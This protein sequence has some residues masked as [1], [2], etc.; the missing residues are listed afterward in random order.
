MKKIISSILTML[1]YI[2]GTAQQNNNVQ[3][4]VV[5]DTV[6]KTDSNSVKLEKITST[7]EDILAKL[8]KNDNDEKQ[9]IGVIKI[10]CDKPINLYKAKNQQKTA[11][12]EKVKVEKVTMQVKDGY[13]IDLNVY[14]DKGSFTNTESPITISTRRFSDSDYLFG[15]RDKSSSILLKEFLMFE[16]YNTY[17]PED[18]FIVL[19]CKKNSDSLF[20]N[21]GVN[22][23]L[24]MRLYTDALSL[25]GKESNGIAQ[26]D[27]RIKHILHRINVKNKGGF[28]GHYF[29]INVNAAKFDSK[30]NFVDS[31]KF[32]R[33]SFVQKSWINAEV[34]YNIL[35]AWIEK[36]S[37]S[38]FYFD[39]GAGINA[40]N[41][42]LKTDTITITG[43]NVL[44]RLG[45]T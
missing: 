20:R 24:D 25:F 40:G 5:K 21:V 1:I 43:Q 2:N 28:L 22:T 41:L 4:A 6:P 16:P 18:G 31:A 34:A 39:I 45:S 14:T 23:V 8:K 26:T 19:D 29:K 35:S 33:T 10:D 17:V 13:I 42:A 38:F 36:K 9:F 27:I 7:L 32:S 3:A 37:L 12:D 30:S 11:A 15:I 44:L